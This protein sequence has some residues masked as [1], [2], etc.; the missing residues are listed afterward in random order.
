MNKPILYLFIAA[1]LFNVWQYGFW[2]SDRKNDQKKFDIV[3]KQYK[4]AKDSIVALNES[5]NE[6][7]YFTLETN[8]NAIDYLEEYDL[9][10]L[11]PYIKEQINT[12]N[13]QPKGNP[14]VPL[15]PIDGNK[16]VINKIKFV[17][18]R[19]IIGDFSN[20]E[21]WGEVIIKYFINQDKTV[22]FETAESVIYSN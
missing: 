3:N 17:N 7:N 5:L 13:D 11:L 12:L 21:I 22:S 14:L 1:L 8:Q 19:W 10:I 20:G 18:H 15:D 4:K 6:A 9:N 16:F 2:A